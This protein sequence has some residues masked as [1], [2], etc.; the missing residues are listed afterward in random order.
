MEWEGMTLEQKHTSFRDI[1]VSVDFG[2]TIG[3][4]IVKGRDFSRAFRTDSTAAI[5]N[6][7]GA[8]ILGFKDPHR[9]DGKTLGEKCYHHRR[10][11]GYGEQQRIR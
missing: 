10:I 2:P 4:T 7:E 3:W 11:E 8:R 9:Q 1:L 5:V 6:E